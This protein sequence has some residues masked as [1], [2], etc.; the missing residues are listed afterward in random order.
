MTTVE[1]RAS[2][3][4]PAFASTTAASTKPRRSRWWSNIPFYLALAWMAA[5]LFCA[6]FAQVIPVPDPNHTDVLNQL[7]GPFTHGHILGTDGLG[8]DIFSR[9]VHGARVSVVISFSAVGVGMAIGGTLGIVIGFFRGKLEIGILA[10]IDVI[11]AF[12]GLVILLALVAVIGQSLSTIALVIGFL[13]IPIYTRVAR[14]NTLAAAQREY[15]LAAKALG[16]TNRRLMFREI[17]P[18]VVLPVLA[19]GLIAV[20]AVIVLEGSLAFLGLSVQLPRATWGG[21]IAEGRRHLNDGA[22]VALI[23]SLVMFLTVL[24][25]NYVGDQFR[26]RFDVRESAL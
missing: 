6:I 18:N 23:P 4:T 1:D 22:H 21:M 13:S 2:T 11:L 17:L 24:S 20:G 15:V 3:T 25:L 7:H 8:R 5:V 19:F 12:P 14:A 26:R 9:L 16:A 10:V